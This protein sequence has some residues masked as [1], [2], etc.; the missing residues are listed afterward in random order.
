MTLT[1]FENTLVTFE[2]AEDYFNARPNSDCWLD[3]PYPKKE[4]AL[5]FASKK[6]NNFDFI[7]EK[8]SAAQIFEFPRNFTPEMPDDIR[9]AVCEEAYALIETSP[10]SKNKQNGISQISLGNTSISYSDRKNT[11]V[12]LSDYAFSL[13][14][15]WT[16]KN[17]DIN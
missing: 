7:G 12:L 4:K 5:I 11:G 8:K 16:R 17:F 6:V 14:S 2:F 9:F 1:L 13:V 15:K 10:H 3:A